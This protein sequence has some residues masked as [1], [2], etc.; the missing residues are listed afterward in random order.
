VDRRRRGAACDAREARGGRG[1]IAD[2]Q[3]R[4][5]EAYAAYVASA[6][7]V[8]LAR[9]VSGEP[10]AHAAGGSSV[11]ETTD[12]RIV[13]VA[14]GL[15]HHWRG[16]IHVPGVGLE[17]VIATAQRYDAYT[18]MYKSVIEA[19]VLRRDGNRFCVLTR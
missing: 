2:L 18:R 17:R 16:T 13:K 1:C 15:V 14:N 3:P 10:V 8:F 4:T 6:E 7:A 9:V 12:G 19:R 11:E 5:T